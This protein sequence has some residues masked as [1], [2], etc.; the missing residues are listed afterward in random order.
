MEIFTLIIV[1]LLGIEHIGI[2][3]FEIFGTP[4]KQAGAFDMPLE[5]V[6]NKNAKVAMANQGI[7]NAMLGVLILLMILLFTGATLKYILILLTSFIFI[8]AAFGALTAT[9]KIIFL[10][11]LP[12]LISLL[13]VIFFYA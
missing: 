1:A 3:L 4:D 2:G 5:F 11:G 6:K 12:A 10:Q 7:Y 13:L 9:K 8:V